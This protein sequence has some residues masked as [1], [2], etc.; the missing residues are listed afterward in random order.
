[1]CEINLCMRKIQGICRG[2]FFLPDSNSFG[3]KYYVFMLS[4]CL[5]PSV[6]FFVI[7]VSQ[8]WGNFFKFRSKYIMRNL[9]SHCVESNGSDN[10]L[11]HEAKCF[12]LGGTIHLM[13]KLLQYTATVRC[14]ESQKGRRRSLRFC[15]MSSLSSLS[16]SNPS[17]L[18]LTAHFYSWPPS[19]D[20]ST[21]R[22]EEQ[23]PG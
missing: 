23:S 16:S 15:A 18:F 3:W 17:W 8:P 1:M 4:F 20:P 7:A 9:K 21:H 6:P 10:K 5:T 12:K 14:R 2:F 11:D 19:L 22:C 13:N